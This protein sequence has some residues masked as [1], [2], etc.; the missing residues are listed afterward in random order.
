M[1]SGTIWV[2]LG[3]LFPLVARG[4]GSMFDL[5]SCYCWELEIKCCLSDGGSLEEWRME[6]LV[7]DR[8]ENTELPLDDTELL[9]PLSLVHRRP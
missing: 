6:E 3:V 1:I 8:E 5:E 9:R 4:D 2:F 7:A